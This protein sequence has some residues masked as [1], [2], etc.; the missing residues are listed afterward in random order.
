[1]KKSFFISILTLSALIEAAVM[2]A[3]FAADGA[4]GEG[5]AALRGQLEARIKAMD[6]NSDGAIDWAEYLANAEDQ[7]RKLD[8][9]G[10]GRITAEERRKVR[11]RVGTLRGG[12]ARFP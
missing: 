8:L 11:E 2:P 6:S 3:A 1:M 9:D 5:R 12:D 7:F 10:D 4:P